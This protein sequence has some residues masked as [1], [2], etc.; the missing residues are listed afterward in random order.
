MSQLRLLLLGFCLSGFLTA[1][2]SIGHAQEKRTQKMIGLYIHQH[3]PYNRPYAARTWTL[4]DW[5][6]WAEGLKKLGYNTVLIWPMLETMPEPLTPSDKAHLQKLGKVIDRLHSDFGMQV[7]I[8][9]CPNIRA[10]NDIA[11][12]ATFEKRHYYYTDELVNPGDADALRRLI[13]WREQLLRP[14]AKVDGIAMIDSDPGGYPGSSNAEFVNLLTEHR[15]MFDRIRPGIELIYWMH[16]G[17]RGWSGFYETGKLTFSTPEE[18]LDTLTRLKNTNPHP[19]GIA[20]GLAYAEKLGVADKVMSF[21]YGVIEGEPSFPMTNFGGR[22]AYDGGKAT[23]ARGVM[24]NAQTHCVQLPNIFAFAR[25]AT[26]KTLT[27]ADYVTFANELIPGLG[28][29]IV[30]G[31]QALT[32]TSVE[33]MRG[34]ADTLERAAAKKPKPGPL[35]GLLFGNASRFLTDLVLMLRMRAAQEEF[36]AVAGQQPETLM[37]RLLALVEAAEAWQKR[38]GY[39]NNWHNP[40]LQAALR[41]LNSPAID[42]VLNVTYEAKEPFESGVKTAGEQVGRNFASLETFTTRLLAAMRAF[43]TEK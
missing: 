28:E 20:N 32:G 35:K 19:W 27:D 4:E 31:W 24:G 11:A 36:I 2:P 1:W 22:A 12:R 17:W 18:Q 23:T 14:L 40:P 8:V 43:V 29:D 16:A 7:Y 9:L 39:Q 41:K 30:K 38:H 33:A 34:A 37:P 26:G 21:N 3:W 6:G 5:S 25:G 10:R 15:K 42:K 13:E